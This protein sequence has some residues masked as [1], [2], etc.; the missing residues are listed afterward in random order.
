[1]PVLTSRFRPP[2]FLGNGHIQT[3]L[4]ALLPPRS[5]I[6]IQR[7]RLELIDGDFLDLDWARI[8]A[9]R[10]T[11][12]SHG[13]EGSSDARYIRGMAAALNAAEWDVLVWN[14]RG[15][16]QETNR[17]PRLYHSGET[18]DLGAVIDFA[19]TRYSRIALV[20]FS[21]GGNLILKY[22]GE[23]NPHPAVIG[24]VAI[25]VPIDLAATARAL[26]HRWSNRI[27]LRRFIKSLIAKVETKARRFPDQVDVSRSRAIRTLQEFADR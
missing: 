10:L 7:E 26:D 12:L 16:S 11:I 9:D 15:C 5:H 8:G 21:L 4:S 25:S 18:G 27:Y 19:A 20:G 17:L 22:L 24:A 14:F 13:L 23:A 6:A 3:V 2:F 1:M